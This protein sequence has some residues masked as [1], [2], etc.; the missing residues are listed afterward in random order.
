MDIHADARFPLTLLR[1]GG[2]EFFA[3]W[4]F[5][6]MH[7]RPGKFIILWKWL[8][9]KQVTSAA[10]DITGRCNLRCLHCYWWEQDHPGELNDRE[11]IDFMKGLRAKGL[12]AAIL[13]GGEPTLRLNVC[14]AATEIFDATL[15]FTNGTNGMPA[16]DNGRWV[17]SLDGDREANDLIRGDGVYDRVVKNLKKAP[18]PP[19]VHMTISRLNQESIDDFVKAM[20]RLPIRKIGFSFFTPSRGSDSSRFFIPLADRDNLVAHLL[21]LRKKYGEI[22]GFTP[23]MARQLLTGGDFPEWNSLASCPVTKRVRC[24]KA[25]GKPKACTYGNDADCSR[26]GCAA[27]VAYRGAFCPPDCQTIRLI[28]DL[29]A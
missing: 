8:F 6:V 19:I 20:T 11:M 15:I 3:D 16:I 24:F 18:N 27:V 2:D 21:V 14:R 7:T 5:F 26:C 29:M 1:R 28:S 17:V 25:D 4:L 23:A 22:I 12:R 13:Y 10:I 9:T